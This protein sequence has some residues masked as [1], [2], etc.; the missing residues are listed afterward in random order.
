M[1]AVVLIALGLTSAAPATKTVTSADAGKTIVIAKHQKLQIELSECG[2]CG[3]RWKTTI[4]PSGKVLTRG[5]PRTKDPTCQDPPCTG[6]S[7]TRVFPYTGKGT[8]KTKIRLEYFG[9]GK[10]DSSESFQITV[11]VR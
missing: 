8:G 6:G 5:A 3:Y 2:S 1:L 4:K 10:Q 11:R 7:E 9:P